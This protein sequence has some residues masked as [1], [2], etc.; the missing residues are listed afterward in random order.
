MVTLECRMYQSNF[1]QV[2]HHNLLN[3]HPALEEPHLLTETLFASVVL[4]ESIDDTG[5]SISGRHRSHERR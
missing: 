3:A 5:V 4:A 1:V 2:W